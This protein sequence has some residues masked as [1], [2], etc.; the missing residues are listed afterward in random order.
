MNRASAVLGSAVFFVIAPAT[1]AG[2]VPWW[3]SGW[4]VQPALLGLPALRGFGVLLIAG[5]I[6]VLLECFARFALEG[7]GT[8]APVLPT[9]HLVINGSYRHVRNP[10]Y[11]AVV[12]VIAGQSLFL[13]NVTLLAYGALIWIGFH[14]FVLA[15]E[16]PTLRKTFGADYDVFCRHVPRWIPRVRPWSGRATEDL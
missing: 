8:P 7:L 5:G 1:I 3:L 15:Y 14:L 11:L 12:A 16:E 9:R 2:L 4:R 6:A 10:I 13:G